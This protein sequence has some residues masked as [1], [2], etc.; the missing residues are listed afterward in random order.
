MTFFINLSIQDELPLFFEELYRHLNS[1][2]LE[3]LP[4]ELGFVKRKRKF[5]GNELAAICIWVSQRIGSDPLVRL[6]SHR[7]SYE[8]RRTH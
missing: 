6:C 4:K 1:S 8:S 5:S 7:H 3:E 2:L